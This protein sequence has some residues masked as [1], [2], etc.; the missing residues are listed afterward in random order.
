LSPVVVEA[1]ASDEKVVRRRPPVWPIFYYPTA[2]SWFRPLPVRLV[3]S[4]SPS[5]QYYPQLPPRWAREA[6]REKEKNQ[7]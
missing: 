7:E 4:F 6:M 2:S 3:A 1:K 5:R